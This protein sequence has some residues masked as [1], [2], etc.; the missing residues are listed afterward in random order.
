VASAPEPAVALEA[1]GVTT[2]DADGAR[3]PVSLSALHAH[4]INNQT[5]R[6]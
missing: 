4:N 5:N 6:A 1:G 2:T 3:A